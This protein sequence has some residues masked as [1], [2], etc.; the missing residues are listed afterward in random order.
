MQN[1][2]QVALTYPVAKG[3]AKQD[4][5]PLRLHADLMLK[6]IVVEGKA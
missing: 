4:I 6:V 3:L 2:W 1:V 5:A